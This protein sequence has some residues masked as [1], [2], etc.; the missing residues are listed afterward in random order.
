MMLDDASLYRIAGISTVVALIAFVISA[1]AL[2]L[3]FG[4]AGEVFGPINDVFI[5]IA[6]VSLIPAIIAV[7]RLA[8]ADTGLWLRIISIL[9]VVG[10]IIGAAGQLLLVVGVIDLDTSYVTG[11]IGFLP[12]VIWIIAIAVL[13]L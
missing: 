6:L 1:I 2:G 9:A 8:G 5:A 7:D 11:G 13:A 12:V 3:F 10:A 4:G